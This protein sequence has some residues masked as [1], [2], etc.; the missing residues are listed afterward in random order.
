KVLT[1]NDFPNLQ[2]V[3]KRLLDFQTRYQEIARPFNWKFTRKDLKERI[4]LVSDH[5][6]DQWQ[7]VMPQDSIT[8]EFE[9]WA[10]IP[11]ISYAYV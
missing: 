6:I 11:E 9:S 8:E 4:K 10:E 2:A 5:I 1:P 3:E 7:S